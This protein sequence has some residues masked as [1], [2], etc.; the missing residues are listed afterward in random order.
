MTNQE[1]YSIE[2]HKYERPIVKPL[3]MMATAH[4]TRVEY[5]GLNNDVNNYDFEEN[6]GEVT[7]DPAIMAAHGIHDAANKTRHKQAA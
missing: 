5:Y 7:V 2:H 1:L 4:T 6:L 3:S